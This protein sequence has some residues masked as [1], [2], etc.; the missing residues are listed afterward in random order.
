MLD[1]TSGLLKFKYEKEYCVQPFLTKKEFN[2]M[3]M[4]V[5]SSS[6][7]KTTLFLPN[8]SLGS[9]SM[10]MEVHFDR[11]NYIDRIT[12]RS[13]KTNGIE[14]ANNNVEM[15]QYLKAIK[16]EHDALLSEICHLPI[17]QNSHSKEVHFDASWG[18]VSSILDC[19]ETPDARIVIRFRNI[20]EGDKNRYLKLGKERL[21]GRK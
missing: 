10:E 17:D 5:P 6:I 16:E 19:S 18:S 4:D 3:I 9:Y 21:Y 7:S 11:N 1:I 20:Q 2:N 13:T 12:L 15:E 14:Q 8:I